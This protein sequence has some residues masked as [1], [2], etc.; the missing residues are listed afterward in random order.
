VLAVPAF[1][2]VENGKDYRL[3]KKIAKGGGGTILLARVL[4]QALSIRS[5]FP[6]IVVKE[7][8]DLSMRSETWREEFLQEVA[9]MFAFQGHPNIV[10]LL[11]Y[12]HNPPSILMKFYSLGTLQD[13]IDG[14]E[15]IAPMAR[16]P[17]SFEGWT[18]GW[19]LSFTGDICAAL[20]CLHDNGVIHC[21]LKVCALHCTLSFNQF[22]VHTSNLNS[23]LMFWWISIRMEKCLP[24]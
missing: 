14:W 10:S 24:Y 19:V 22:N 8:N 1:Y 2:E 17:L 6:F 21:D 5:K 16:M 11:G 3:V 9:L 7:L 4:S 15:M 20:Q 18:V 13:W 12:C 23:H